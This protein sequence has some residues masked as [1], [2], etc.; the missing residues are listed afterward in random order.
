MAE[1]EARR[2]ELLRQLGGDVTAEMSQ[3]FIQ[4]A[5][6]RAQR[7][8]EQDEPPAGPEQVVHRPQRG[9]VVLDVLQDVQADDGVEPLGDEP[10]AHGGEPQLGDG[11]VRPAREPVAQAAE[12]IRLRV[13]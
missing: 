8:H 6:Q 1:T 13:R 10:G 9:A 3:R 12:V 4:G 2:P 11:H 5:V 7:R